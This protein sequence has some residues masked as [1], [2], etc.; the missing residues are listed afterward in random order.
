MEYFYLKLCETAK[1]LLEHKE[2]LVVIL[3]YPDHLMSGDYYNA[4]DIPLTIYLDL[5]LFCGRTGYGT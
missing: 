5:Y 4:A 2:K 3:I 1:T